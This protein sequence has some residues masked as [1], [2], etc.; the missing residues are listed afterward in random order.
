MFADYIGAGFA[1]D[2][3]WRLTLQEYHLHMRGAGRRLEREHRERAWLA[4]TIGILAQTSGRKYPK[5]SSLIGRDEVRVEK[6][7]EALLD[8]A[9]HWHRRINREN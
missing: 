1:P 2:G 6:T 5:L 3:F 9:H 4:H 7:P 8:I